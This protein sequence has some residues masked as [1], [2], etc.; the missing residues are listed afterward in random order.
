MTRIVGALIV[1][2]LAWWIFETAR[3]EQD[4]PHQIAYFVLSVLAMLLG[5][6]QIFL[7]IFRW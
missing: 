7:L 3:Q 4:R 2:L 1:L 5:L 6:F